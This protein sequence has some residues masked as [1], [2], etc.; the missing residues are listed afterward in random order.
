MVPKITLG[1]SQK[2]VKILSFDIWILKRK[3]ELSTAVC[4]LLNK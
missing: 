3:Q 1:Y 4:L 2:T